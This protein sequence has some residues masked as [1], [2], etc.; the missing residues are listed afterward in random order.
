MKSEEDKDAIIAALR[1][2][3]K[4]L[5]SVISM[6]PGHV[7]WRDTE[8][9]YL[10]CNAKVANLLNLKSPDDLIGKS[11]AEVMETFFWNDANHADIADLV[12]LVNQEEIYIE[13]EA[14]DIHGA[15]ALY[16]TQRSPLYDEEGNIQGVVGISLDITARKKMEENL[17]IAKQRA[18]AASRAKSQFLAMVSHELRTPLTSIL[19]F[20][21][22][23]EKENISEEE[24]TTYIQHIAS[25]GT[26]LFSLINNLLDYNKLETNKYEIFSVPLNLKK[27]MEEILSMLSGSA[28]FKNLDLHLVYADNLPTYVISDGQAL[29]QILVNLVGN[30]IK[31]T[32]KGHVILR[33][34]LVNQKP[35]ATELKIAVEDTGIGIPLNQQRAIFKQ[36]HQLGNV[37]TRNA[38]LTGTGLGLA[39][40][41]KLV[42]LMGS[43]IELK[44]T[45]KKGSVFSF[46]LYLTHARE[47]QI[48]KITLPNTPIETFKNKKPRVLLIEDD[49]L[50]QLVHRKMLEDLGCQVK[51]ADCAN[52][53]LDM[54]QNTYDIIFSDIGLPDMNGFELIKQLRTHSFSNDNL[55]IIALTGYS[56]AEEQQRCFDAGAN[57]VAVKPVSQHMLKH[58]LEEYL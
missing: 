16:L 9:K 46:N 41:R 57:H 28:K 39:I 43:R 1:A 34:E 55:P 14:F 13:E 33:V 26:Y 47:E 7:Y 53:A 52:Q 54:L 23:L 45:P 17:R 40:V 37:Y 51:T 48:E 58:L 31:F 27:L 56:E 6:M 35:N 19:G 50:I 4:T 32:E 24:K 12:V 25:S 30:A 49:A 15:P 21:S 44:S 22:F 3:V 2:E 36:F 20:I 8:G 29:K 18:E 5:K 42:K 10:G 11:N 38:S